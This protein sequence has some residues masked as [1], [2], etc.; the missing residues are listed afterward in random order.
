MQGFQS[1]EGKLLEV[2]LWSERQEEQDPSRWGDGGTETTKGCSAGVRTT[3]NET[4]TKR[5]QGGRDNAV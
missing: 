1:R 4:R 3:R 5:K 2:Q